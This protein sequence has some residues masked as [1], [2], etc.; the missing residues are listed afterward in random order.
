[1]S[2]NEPDT[3]HKAFLQHAAIAYAG[4]AKVLGMLPIPIALKVQLDTDPSDIEDLLRARKL[5]REI[6]MEQILIAVV[7]TMIVEWMAAMTLA[8]QIDPDDQSDD[9][10]LEAAILNMLRVDSSINVALNILAD[11]RAKK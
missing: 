4:I 11:R 6:P 3:F 2:E 9:W 5:V 10:L 1:M 7:N 8:G